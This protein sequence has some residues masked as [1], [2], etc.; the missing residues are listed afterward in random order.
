M[1][2]LTDFERAVLCKLLSGDHPV[3]AV[4]REQLEVCRCTRRE[5]TGVGFYTYCDVSTYTGPRPE[6]NLKFGDVVAEINGLQE[7]AGFV[8]YVEAGLLVMLEGYSFGECWP[9]RIDSFE[10]S[11][12]NGKERDWQ[13]LTKLLDNRT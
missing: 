10:L 11:Y 13:A 3:L 2:D 9:D 6:I 5:A 7:S 1:T 4:L 12:I 8:V